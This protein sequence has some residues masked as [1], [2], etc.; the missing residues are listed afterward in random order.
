MRYDSRSGKAFVEIEVSGSLAENKVTALE[1]GQ[2]GELWVGGINGVRRYVPGSGTVPTVYT[3]IGRPSRQQYHGHLPRQRRPIWVGST[4]GGVSRID[5][6]VATRMDLGRSFTA[7][8]FTQDIDGR[9]WVGTEGQ[10]IIVLEDGKEVQQFTTEEGLLSNT[11]KALGRGRVRS[12]MDRHEQGA[13]QMA[14]EEGRVHRLHGTGWI[15]RY[16]GEA[17]CRMD[18]AAGGD[19]WFGTANGATRVGSEKESE[20]TIPPLVAIRGWKVNLEDRAVVTDMSLDHTERN[21]RIAYGSV[22]LSDPGSGAVPVQT[23]GLG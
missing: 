22:S 17:Q 7:S 23:E 13:E 12:C 21:V 11:I 8:C 1:I 3:G 18:R 15:H 19:L 6:G 14:S 16:R 10:G 9:I 20:Q 2:P 4:V 5:N